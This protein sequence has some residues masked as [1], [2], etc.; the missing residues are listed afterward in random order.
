M[1]LSPVGR[2]GG[3]RPVKR[4]GLGGGG[5]R[6]GGRAPDLND[7]FPLFFQKIN[8]N[9]TLIFP[10]LFS[11]KNITNNITLIGYPNRPAFF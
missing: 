7:F 3:D 6:P 5:S 2:V 10:Y 9:N 4:G 1:I 8:T 11:P